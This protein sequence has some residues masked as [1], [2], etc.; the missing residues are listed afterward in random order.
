M[1][2]GSNPEW[3]NRLKLGESKAAAGLSFFKKINL[4]MIGL[5]INIEGILVILK[6]FA[7]FEWKTCAEVPL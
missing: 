7:Y 6:Y 3:K 4:P 5:V 2:L 1:D